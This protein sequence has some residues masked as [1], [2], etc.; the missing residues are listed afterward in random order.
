MVVSFPK[1]FINPT[2]RPYR[3]KFPR[4]SSGTTIKTFKYQYDNTS[5]IDLCTQRKQNFQFAGTTRDSRNDN[6]SLK[7]SNLV[8]IWKGVVYNYTISH[9]NIRDA[10]ENIKNYKHK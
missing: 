5:K 10:K 9:T 8:F 1:F 6:T 3:R 4:P 7:T 2:F